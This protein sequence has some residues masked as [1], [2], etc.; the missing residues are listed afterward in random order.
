MAKSGKRPGFVRIECKDADEAQ[1][2]ERALLDPEV[3]AYVVVVGLLMP[4]TDRA[5]ARTASRV[6]SSRRCRR[7][8]RLRTR[9]RHHSSV[10]P[11]S[12]NWG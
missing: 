8:R 6:V 11:L 10:D 4:L 9:E 3:R 7:L 12:E 2:I 1:A 5:R